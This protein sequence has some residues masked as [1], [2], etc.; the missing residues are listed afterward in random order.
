MN[1]FIVPVVRATHDH[2]HSTIEPLTP[3][4]QEVCDTV[5]E[6]GLNEPYDKPLIRVANIIDSVAHEA[7]HEI[8]PLRSD[9]LMSVAYHL[10]SQTAILELGVTDE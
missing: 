7:A 1:A 8:S 6:I 9:Y 3:P 10:V 5:Y 2:L 4:P